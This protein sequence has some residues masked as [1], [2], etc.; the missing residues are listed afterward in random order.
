MVRS[1]FSL[2]M[3]H[4]KKEIEWNIYLFACEWKTAP[5][6]NQIKPVE[7]DGKWLDV[8][9]SFIRFRHILCK[10]AINIGW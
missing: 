4:Q 9:I 1:R 10:H 2:C 8:A 5:S 7:I 6:K 3:Q